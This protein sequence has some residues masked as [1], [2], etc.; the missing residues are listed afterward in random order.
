MIMVFQ[1]FLILILFIIL[2]ALGRKVLKLLQIDFVAS[3][4]YYII[5][6]VL[7]LGLICHLMFFIGMAGGLY[8][9]VIIIVILFLT[10]FLFNEI[11]GIVKDV[12]QL[13]KNISFSNLKKPFV[14]YLIMLLLFLLGT[15]NFISSSAPPTAADTLAYHLAAPKI[16]IQNH[17]IEFIPYYQF[18]F[19]L[20]YEMVY[21]LGMMFS[22]G[23][24]TGQINFVVSIVLLCSLIVFSAKY[25][26]LLLSCLIGL[27]F[28]AVPLV[29]MEASIAKNDLAVML[30][31]VLCYSTLIKYREE[32]Y[33]LKWLVLSGIFCGFALATKLNGIT[34]FFIMLLIYLF[35][36]I[37]DVKIRKNII[38]D[39]LIFSVLSIL[40]A[41]PWYIKNLF[42]TGN[43]VWPAFDAVFH[44]KYMNY[45][46]QAK[47]SEHFDVGVEKN[48]LNF[49]LCPWWVVIKG[50][51]FGTDR[52]GFSP[53]FLVVLPF[54]VFVLKKIDKKQLIIALTSLLFCLIYYVYWFLTY[55]NGVLLFPIIPFLC[56][57]TGT[58]IK[59]LFNFQNKGI[60][61]VVI[62]SIIIS[63]VWGIC[64]SVL[65]N[66]NS[67]PV[68][69]GW[70]KKDDFI[71]NNV[72]YYDDYQYINK[73]LS[74]S[75][76]L[77]LLPY[78]GY[79]L[80]VKYVWGAPG[81][82]GY[83]SYGD[84]NKEEI[85]AKIKSLKITHVFVDE[86][87]IPSTY[88]DKMVKL[89]YELE[90]DN[91]IIKIYT[92]PDSEKCLSRALKRIKFCKTCLYKIL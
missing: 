5:S 60:K 33:Q 66:R 52:I 58:I 68:V 63:V 57:L 73:T 23:A 12:I 1:I 55:H 47:I 78:M 9:N 18:G 87:E 28:Y 37:Y 40:V 7:G 50:K 61:V 19:P 71:S 62:L 45:E 44:G 92:N 30:F 88:K 36:R 2:A 10:V 29:T 34:V 31:S 25:F 48:V 90:R 84:F 70:Q 77:L 75:D 35:L 3:S 17:R 6:I 54:F 46:L 79:Y 82:Q 24:I 64:V 72:W 13:T 53:L 42:Y 51:L 89:L 81:F 38:R 86:E 67:M 91:K 16:F 15:L 21:L 69:L 26:N 39:L 22:D 27:I 32:N 65:Y 85:L 11:K 43:P 74:K 8:R 80:D 59:G 14:I 83:F 49:L 4:E 76:K 20:T 56:L 41:S